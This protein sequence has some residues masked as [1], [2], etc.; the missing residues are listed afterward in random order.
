MYIFTIMHG[1][2][3]SAR[4]AFIF[5]FPYSPLFYIYNIYVTPGNG[6]LILRSLLDICSNSESVFVNNMW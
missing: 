6:I 5:F 3:C 2:V 4:N 1:L